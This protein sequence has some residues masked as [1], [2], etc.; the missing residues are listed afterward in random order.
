MTNLANNCVTMKKLI[1]KFYK[2]TELSDDIC[3]KFSKFSGKISKANF[4]IQQ[5]VLKL[6]I[7]PRIFLQRSEHNFE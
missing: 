1:D 7:N 6:P 4:E 5:S 2:K 3:E